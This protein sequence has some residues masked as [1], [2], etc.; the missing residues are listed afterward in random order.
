MGRPSRY[1]PE[2]RERAVR[3][4]F[5]D[6]RTLGAKETGGRTALP[7]FRDIMLRVY[8]DRLAGPVPQFPREIEEGIDNYLARQAIPEPGV[9]Q[10]PLLTPVRR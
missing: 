4:G 9:D 10:L 8:K 7:I 3:I 1:S 5:D 6:N 2:V